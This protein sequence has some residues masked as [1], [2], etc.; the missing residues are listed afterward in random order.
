MQINGVN[1]AGMQ[2]QSAVTGIGQKTDAYSRKLQKQIQD[3]QQRIQDISSDENLSPEEKMKKR[4]EI[5]Q[6][7]NNLNIQLRQHQMEL[8]KE[9]QKEKSDSAVTELTGGRS[10]KAGKEGGQA[11][12]MSNAS[13]SAII[14]ADAAVKQ[15]N[16][17][18]NVANRMENRADVI[19]SEIKMDR[20]DTS[21]K[22]KALAETE[23]RAQEASAAQMSTLKEAGEELKQAEHSEENK[24]HKD[25][26]D[27]DKAKEKKADDA[28]D[29]DGKEEE[30]KETSYTPVD[31][32]L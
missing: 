27:A 21:D 10:A 18:G 12:T 24:D 30:K 17:Q 15:A 16:V 14:S 11:K 23:K 3:A 9:K 1:G 32:R 6:E 4:Q 19:K 20:G 29:V 8:R 28:K 5:Q 31:I 13:M 2:N 25:T 26:S 7:I 22:E